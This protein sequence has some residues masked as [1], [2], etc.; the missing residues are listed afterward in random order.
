MAD[1]SLRTPGS[2]ETFASDDVGGVKHQRVKISLG[3]DGVA[4]DM[5][6]NTEGTLLAS[7][8]RTTATTTAVQTNHNARGVLLTFNATVVGTGT[9]TLS[10]EVLDPVSGNNYAF[11]TGAASGAGQNS[12]L[13]YPGVLDADVTPDARSC[14]L[15]RTWQAKV[16][17]SD[18]SSWTYSLGY[19]L[20]L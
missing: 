17:K 11:A 1:N 13:I 15:P 18:G 12:L 16:A 19:S 4:A 10:V 20:I 8:A 2:G 6:G 3:A 7:A 9:A 14:A 5:L